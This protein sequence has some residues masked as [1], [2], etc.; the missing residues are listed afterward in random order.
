[1]KAQFVLPT[2]SRYP[3]GSQWKQPHWRQQV[4]CP[5]CKRPCWAPGGYD[6]ALK[7]KAHIICQDCSS[8]VG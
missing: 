3:P 5:N 7:A 4:G 2:V 8:R 1:M 6:E